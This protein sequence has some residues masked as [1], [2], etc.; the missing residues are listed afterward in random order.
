MLVR[1]S[2]KKGPT[3]TRRPDL[4]RGRRA[5]E[6]DQVRRIHEKEINPK[7]AALRP[8]STIARM[9]ETPANAKTQIR[10]AVAAIGAKGLDSVVVAVLRGGGPRC[11]E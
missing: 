9:L 1:W 4:S 8:E 11:G 2:A 5:V 10:E 6:R 7:L 3:W